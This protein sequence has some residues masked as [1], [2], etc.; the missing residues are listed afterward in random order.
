MYM[1]VCMFGVGLKTI[2]ICEHGDSALFTQCQ[3]NVYKIIHAK[4][5][6]SASVIVMTALE[7]TR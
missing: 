6:H 4:A 7:D 3:H 2:H 5:A 1:Y